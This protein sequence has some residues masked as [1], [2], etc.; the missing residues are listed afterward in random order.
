MSRLCPKAEISLAY[1]G[2]KFNTASPSQ[3][4]THLFIQF[5]ASHAQSNHPVVREL[6]GSY[7]KDKA[8]LY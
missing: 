5:S 1:E 2:Q 7:L 8:R 4:P 6:L 3:N